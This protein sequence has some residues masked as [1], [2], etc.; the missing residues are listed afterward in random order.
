MPDLHATL[1]AGFASTEI[2]PGKE[3]SLFGYGF[4]QEKLSPGNEGVHDPLHIRAMV[5][6]DA[7]YRKLVFVSFDLCVIPTGLAEAWRREV[8]DKL[9]T[10]AERVFLSA[11]HTHSGPLL[12]TEELARDWGRMKDGGPPPPEIAYTEEV[13]RRMLDAVARAQ[14]LKYPVAPFIQQAPLGLAYDRRVKGEDGGV[15]LCWEPQEFPDRV[16]EPAVDPA[17]SVFLLRQTNGQRQ[18]VLWNFGAHPVVLGK[19][20]KVVSADFPGLAN[21]MLEEAMPGARALFLNGACGHNQPWLATQED[22]ANAEIVARGAASF[23]HLLAEGSRNVTTEQPLELKAASTTLE[24]EEVK[25]PLSVARIGDVR[26]AAV[27]VEL[28]GELAL[29]LREAVDGPLLLTTLTNGWEGYLP[30]EAAFAEG[31][32]EVDIAQRFGYQ[33][34]DGERTVEA[35]LSL[36]DSL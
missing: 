27:P 28:F 12:L 4:R 33:P 3:L 32:Y 14:G 6:E 15:T 5:L 31:G 35:L 22:P 26:I 25:L 21:R 16:P 1:R 34:G 10:R 29:S 23:V 20:S 11:T 18:F 7:D 30:H 24:L 13:R 8:A 9:D 2:T 17:C 36:L 19:T